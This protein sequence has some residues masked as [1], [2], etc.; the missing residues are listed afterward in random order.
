MESYAPA[1]VLVNRKHE[2][3]YSIGPID[4]FLRVATGLPTHDLLSMAHQDIRYKLRSA[5]Q[6][7]IQ[8][9]ARIVIPGAQITHNGDTT[10]FSIDVQ[11][12]SVRRRGTAADLFR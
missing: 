2:C 11:A 6:Q 3:L 9:N 4:R 5:M 8:Q 7:A 1:A 10:S 12:N